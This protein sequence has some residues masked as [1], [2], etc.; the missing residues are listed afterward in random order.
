VVPLCERSG[1]SEMRQMDS[2]SSRRR[3][4][5]QSGRRTR[6]SNP[7]HSSAESTTNRPDTSCFRRAG[8]GRAIAKILLEKALTR[9]DIIFPFQDGHPGF[10]ITH[11]SNVSASEL[12]FV[13]NCY[14]VEITMTES[15]GPRAINPRS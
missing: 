10:N 1:G 2:R 8:I 13:H 14:Y 9:V 6:N 12:N 15:I 3:E 5:H 4:R 11:R 7:A